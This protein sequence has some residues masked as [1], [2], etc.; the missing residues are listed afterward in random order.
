MFQCETHYFFICF[1]TEQKREKFFS[2]R[3]A[4]QWMHRSG[5]VAVS[6]IDIRRRGMTAWAH[7]STYALI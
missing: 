6:A 4:L 3:L 2:P 7:V 5:S 1:R